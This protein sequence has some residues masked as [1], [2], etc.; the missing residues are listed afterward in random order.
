MPRPA[1]HFYNDGDDDDDD[2]DEVPGSPSQS[3]EDL[4]N[5]SGSGE[6]LEDQLKVSKLF[7]HP[8]RV[9]RSSAQ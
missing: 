3:S 1:D 8:Q 6:T 4:E 5:E 2:D 7:P 9:L